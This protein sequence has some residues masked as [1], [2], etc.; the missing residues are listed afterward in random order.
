MK[1]YRQALSL[2]VLITLLIV[3]RT[4]LVSSQGESSWDKNIKDT[5]EIVQA[6]ANSQNNRD[7]APEMPEQ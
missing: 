2:L 3:I 1:K 7:M 6:Q 4:P 5:L